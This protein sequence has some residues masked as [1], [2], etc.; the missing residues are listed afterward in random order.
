MTTNIL[1]GYTMIILFLL[2][3]KD[4]K[5]KERWKWKMGAILTVLIP[6]IIA[7]VILGV[8]LSDNTMTKK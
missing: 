3:Y 1:L 4:L 6:P 7:W 5:W 2:S 8:M